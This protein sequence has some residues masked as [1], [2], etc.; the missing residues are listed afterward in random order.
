MARA[1]AGG[2]DLHIHLAAEITRKPYAVVQAA[3]QAGEKWAINA[4]NLAKVGNFGRM[5]GLGARGFVPYAAG[6]G[7]DVDIATAQ[8]VLAAWDRAWVPG[9]MYLDRISQLLGRHSTHLTVTQYG[10]NARVRGRCTYTQAAN[11]LFQGLVADIAKE[12][13]W[14]VQCARW[15]PCSPLHQIVHPWVFVHDEIIAEVPA[16]PEVATQATEGIARIMVDTAQEYAPD[17]VW[18]AD[19][20]VMTKWQK[21]AKE[22]RNAGGYLVPA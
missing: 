7:L 1:I 2:V 16:D 20:A 6:Y 13:L 19:M 18:S 17:V 10:S 15:D 9:R 11:T 22:H 8:D 12:A 21:G 14:R 5:G 4:R 3:Y